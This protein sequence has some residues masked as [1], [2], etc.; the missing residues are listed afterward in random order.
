MPDTARRVVGGRGGVVG[1]LKCRAS[2]LTTSKAVGFRLEISSRFGN[3][4]SGHKPERHML[5]GRH[6][7]M[8]P[9]PLLFFS[10]RYNLHS[11]K[12]MVLKYTGPQF[13]V[14]TR[15]YKV[16]KLRTFSSLQNKPTPIRHPSLSRAATDL[17]YPSLCG[18]AY[19]EHDP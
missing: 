14:F 8:I 16:I 13:S 3:C 11:M 15:L 2:P 6:S 19:S 5:R 12:F 17:L 18:L 9:S 1:R 4:V 7:E 10:S